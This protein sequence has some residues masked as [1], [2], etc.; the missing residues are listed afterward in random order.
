MHGPEGNFV[1]KRIIELGGITFEIRI[2]SQPGEGCPSQSDHEPGRDNHALASRVAGRRGTV[3]HTLVRRVPR[4]RAAFRLANVC[5]RH[6]RGDGGARRHH[7]LT[8]RDG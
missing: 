5:R 7:V 4:L 3:P 2:G 6:P 8:L 1:Y